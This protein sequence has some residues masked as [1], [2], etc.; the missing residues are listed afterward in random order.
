[1]QIILIFCVSGP[2]RD[3]AERFFLLAL[4]VILLCRAKLFNLKNIYS[5][6]ITT[7]KYSATYG[8]DLT[9][10]ITPA[11]NLGYLAPPGQF[12]IGCQIVHWD[13]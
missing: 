8:T 3:V 7:L 12:F 11:S 6:V 1:M 10:R 5:N 2:R 4:V 13:P 9:E